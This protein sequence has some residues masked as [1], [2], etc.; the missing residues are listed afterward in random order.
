MSKMQDKLAS[1]TQAF[2]EALQVLATARDTY[3]GGT[4]KT[5][6]ALRAQQDDLRAKITQ[7]R[8]TAEAAQS[9][10]KR[11]FA[12]AGHV[13]T[14]EVQKALF[15]KN[16]ALS[17]A[18]E[19]SIALKES[20]ATSFD[21]KVAA[22]RDAQRYDAAYGRAFEAYARQQI[23]QALVDCEQSMG[24]ALALAQHVPLPDGRDR[25]AVDIEDA[26]MGFV[27]AELKALAQDRHEAHRRPA[28]EELGALDLGPF[29]DRDFVSPAMAAQARKAM[30]SGTTDR[31]ELAADDGGMAE[32]A[33]ATS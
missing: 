24:R 16:D 15:A 25:I 20:E 13:V 30:N 28:V 5:Y 3:E 12:D 19:L 9:T 23:Y 11:L 33:T 18:E 4:G 6:A 1:A 10:F 22:S 27:W 14:K 21:A 31:D 2:T 7:H 17:I 29:A 8:A 32:A 26:R